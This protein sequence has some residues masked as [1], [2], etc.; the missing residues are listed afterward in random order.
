MMT[1]AEDKSAR[2]GIQVL[3]RAALL[4]SKLEASS[5]PLS[6]TA[7]AKETGLSTSTVHRI[8]GSLHSMGFVKQNA[9]GQWSLGL[10]LLELGNLVYERFIVRQRALPFMQQLHAKTHMTVNLAIRDNDRLLY[11]E[12]VFAPEQ[13][14]NQLRRI[15]SWAPL[16]ITSGGKL[17]LSRMS[18]EELRAYSQRTSLKVCTEHSIQ[19]LDKLLM[20]AL[21][22]AESGL[23]M[24][25]KIKISREDYVRSTARSKLRKGM[26]M[27]RSAVL[28]AALMSS[29][30]RAATALARTYPGGRK[31]FVQKMNET[32][33]RLGMDDSEF[34]DPSGLDNR[35]HATAR[36]L[37][38]LVAE[39]HKYEVIRE[40]S[41]LPSARVKAG[42]YQ[43]RL[44]TTNRLIGNPDWQ[45]GVQKTG[46]TTAAGRC[47][48]VQSEFADR[49]VVMVLLDS[50]NSAQR[51]QDMQ[52]M[53]RFVEN[54]ER[55]NEQFSSVRPFEMF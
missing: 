48:V 22:I 45:I 29:D 41:T 14:A 11:I 54:E 12:H 17:F 26:V 6:L 35:N 44:T 19:C 4:L 5:E 43:L 15:G 50:P 18:P 24:N 2:S 21:V 8:L 32:A 40:S 28:K 34:A 55:I 39:A 10:R 31:A 23:S 30:N 7:L 3:D 1:N 36:D 16:H 20:T 47:M 37:A 52:T 27:T 53:R 33:Q 42:R 49:R 13:K 38:K 25:E 9:I 51:A 46:F